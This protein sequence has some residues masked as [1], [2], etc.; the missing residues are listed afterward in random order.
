MRRALAEMLIAGVSTT[1]PFQQRVLNDRSFRSGDVSTRLVA[2]LAA[3]PESF[4][5]SDGPI[6]LAPPLGE[7][8]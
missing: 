7:P 3:R 6:G 8:A 4:S 1:I 2:E 5:F